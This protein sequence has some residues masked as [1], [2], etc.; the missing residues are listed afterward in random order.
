M[1]INLET[2]N[3]FYNRNLTPTE[4]KEFID[5]EIRK[6]GITQPKNLEEKAVSLI[7]RPLYEAFIKGY[8]IKQWNKDPK[9]LPESIIARLPI[10]YNYREDYFNNSRWQGIPLNGYTKVFERMMDNPN[11]LVKLNTDYF[12]V[13]DSI[14]VRKK[15]IYT[16]PVDQYFN[17]EY[18]RLDWRT[19]NLERILA[20]VEDYQG[21]SVMNIADIDNPCTRIHEPRHLH[22][23]RNYTDKKTIYFKETS[24]SIP[25]KPYYPINTERN[26]KLLQQYLRMALDE[27]HVIFGGRL[28]NYAYYDM[29]I[30]ID[31]AIECFLT[32]IKGK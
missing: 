14:C 22:P 17:Y 25:D 24:D 31:K 2:I 15:T 20:E 29:D 30:T 26:Q 21:T 3:S 19:V 1:P 16:G 10:R 13:K 27:K 9:K 5:G 18:G 28:G 6:E 23:E 11:I 8:T 4:A 32:E 12:A 7:G